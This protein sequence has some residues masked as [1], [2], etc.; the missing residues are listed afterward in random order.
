[1]RT[2]TLDVEKADTSALEAEVALGWCHLPGVH[3]TTPKRSRS[4]RNETRYLWEKLPGR[5]CFNGYLEDPEDEE[6]EWIG[7]QART[8]RGHKEGVETALLGLLALAP[9][10][11]DGMRL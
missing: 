2:S 1:M 6:S 9:P 4:P 8:V 11:M 3:T 7:S 5:C 10:P